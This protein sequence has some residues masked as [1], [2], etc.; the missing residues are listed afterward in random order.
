MFFCVWLR[1]AVRELMIW[2]P[3][4]SF[5]F[6]VLPLVLDVGGGGGCGPSSRRHP[7]IRALQLDQHLLTLLVLPLSFAPTWRHLVPA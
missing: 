7:T 5:F 3:T 1:P 6:P 2:V 4:C